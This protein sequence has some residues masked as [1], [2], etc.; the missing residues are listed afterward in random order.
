MGY[1]PIFYGRKV[2][3]ETLT[4]VERIIAPSLLLLGYELWGTQLISQ[5][6]GM[7]LRVYIDAVDGVTVEDCAKA[8]H[9]ISAVLDVEDPLE[10]AYTLEVS[11]PGSD[12]P[13]FK[14]EQFKRYAGFDVKVRLRVKMDN[15][16]NFTGKIK[17]V[18]EQKVTV[19]VDEKDY[20]LE[21]AN[22]DKANLVSEY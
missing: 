19:T 15:R 12:R 21:L 6:Q 20:E 1:K 3:N 9:Q 18:A 2:V 10:E 11:S 13:L 5:G 16:R 7:K 17:A 22:I 8:S 14:E 4:N